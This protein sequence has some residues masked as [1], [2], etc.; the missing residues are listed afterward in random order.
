MDFVP[1]KWQPYVGD[2]QSA[3]E[4]RHYYE[5]CALLE[6]RAALR[7]GDVWLEHSRRYAAPE[8]YLISRDRWPEV[9]SE[10]CKQIGVSENSEVIAGALRS[11]WRG[12]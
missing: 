5:L 6:L 9:R 1:P 4:R 8:T 7:S 2:N 12:R 11:A 10:V 3:T